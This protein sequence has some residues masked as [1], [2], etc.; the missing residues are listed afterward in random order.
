[1]V[2]RPN[3]ECIAHYPTLPVASVSDTVQYYVEK[4]GFDERFLWGDPPTHAGVSLGDSTVHFSLGEPNPERHGLYFHIADA[5]ELHAWYRETGIESISEPTTMP[6]GMR[7]FSVRDSNGY[8]LWFGHSDLRAG[9]P[10]E[11]ERVDANVRLEKRLLAL[12]GDLAEHKRLT[13]NETLEEIVLHS[14]E[15]IPQGNSYGVASP[16]TEYTLDVIAELQKKHG[17]DYEVHD[18]YRFVEKDGKSGSQ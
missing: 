2:G 4:L 10:V 9:E 15:K 3:I 14:F 13:L 18:S 1:M 5:D 11:I 8:K 12:L 16:H 7:E 17:I 6:W